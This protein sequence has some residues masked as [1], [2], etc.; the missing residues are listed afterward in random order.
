MMPLK[1]YS[2]MCSIKSYYN[3]LTDVVTF[4]YNLSIWFRFSTLEISLRRNV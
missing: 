4:V 1:P 3:N 2:M